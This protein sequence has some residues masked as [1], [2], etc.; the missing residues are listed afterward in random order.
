MWNLTLA[1]EDSDGDG[2][3]VLLARARTRA[4][5]RKEHKRTTLTGTR[6]PCSSAPPCRP[7]GW[8]LGD[9]CGN[10]TGGTAAPTWAASRT[11]VPPPPAPRSAGDARL[12]RP[13]L[14]RSLARSPA[15]S[16]SPFCSILRSLPAQT[17]ISLPGLKSMVPKT[18][19]LPLDWAGVCGKNPC[20]DSAAAATTTTARLRGAGQA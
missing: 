16:S 14:A 2:W 20:P 19:T 7:N 11:R 4:C 6:H 1:C 10:W 8:E 13:S 3:R 9:P 18:R 15:F 5:A 17:D 12:A